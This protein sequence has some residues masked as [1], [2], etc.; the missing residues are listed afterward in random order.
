MFA[1]FAS[2]MPGENIEGKEKKENREAEPG[3]YS[4][5]WEQAGMDSVEFAGDAA[6]EKT[7]EIPETEQALEGNL[8]ERLSEAEAPDTVEEWFVMLKIAYMKTGQT[9]EVADGMARDALETIFS[10]DINQEEGLSA[11]NK[12]QLMRLYAEIASRAVGVQ[13]ELDYSDKARYLTDFTQSLESEMNGAALPSKES[14]AAESSSGGS[15]ESAPQSKSISHFVA[16]A[17]PSGFASRV[18][19][20]APNTTASDEPGVKFD[21]E[22]EMKNENNSFIRAA[23]E[24][25]NAPTNIIADEVIHE[26][27]FEGAKTQVDGVQKRTQEVRQKLDG[28]GGAEKRVD[29]A[30]GE[31]DNGPDKADVTDLVTHATAE[32]AAANVAKRDALDNVLDG[33]TDELEKAQNVIDSAKADIELSLD[34]AASAGINADPALKALERLEEDE[35]EIAEAKALAE[36]NAEELQDAAEGGGAEDGGTKQ[37]MGIFGNGGAPIGD[38]NELKQELN[39]MSE[40]KKADDDKEED[41]DKKPTFDFGAYADPLAN[42]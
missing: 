35:S 10:D 7:G 15:G 14:L 19:G 16:D 33:S 17:A 37:M 9:E 25:G 27:G 28:D 12:Q 38:I 39:K 42:E 11:D 6:N 29:S 40:Q 21:G 3:A 22:G 36:A 2:P 23:K 24:S 4:D 13:A 20:E 26:A 5:I 18:T 31:Q 30:D 34:K 41:K 32:A 1:G 8:N